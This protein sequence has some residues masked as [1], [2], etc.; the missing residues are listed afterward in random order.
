MNVEG[1][2][3]KV[4]GFDSWTGGIHHYQRLTAALRDHGFSLTLVHL[5]SWG[6]DPGRPK[7]ELIGDI[8]VRDV[9]YYDKPDLL[10]ILEQEAPAAVLFLSTDTFAHRAFN[11]YCRMKGIPTLNLYH[12]LVRVQA[13]DAG[14]PYRINILAH[15]RFVSARLLKALQLVWPAYGKALWRTSASLSAW[16]RFAKDI[17]MGGL[18]RFSLIS[19]ED[20]R[21]DRCGVYVAADIVHAVTKYGFRED[22][23]TAVGN[24]DLSRFG[25][26]EAA[27]GSHVASVSGERK[28]VMYVDTGLIYTG[29][30]FNSPAEFIGH[31]VDTSRALAQIG[32]SLVFKPHPDHLRTDVP[33]RLR[34][35]GIEV[36]DNKE[37]VRRLEGC[38]ASIVEP[39]TLAV[40]PALI[41][42]PL[43]LAQYGRLQEQRF[44]SVLE[45]Y[46]RAQKLTSLAE[47]G[48]VYA[49]SG[50]AIN[51]DAVKR[52]IAE[53][54]GPMPPEGMPAR[55]CELVESMLAA[56]RSQRS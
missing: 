42:M 35:A 31:M 48:S 43:W 49:R 30:V 12:G 8:P 21:T 19:A 16:R 51:G 40:I 37:F 54:A 17:L 23:V 28:A 14:S 3:T 44:G 11:R 55:V 2:L 33:Q 9:S 38:C 46:P 26:G 24:P 4:L 53:N 45:S 41:G 56:K 36:C 47:M 15:V 7:S 34:D 50:E 6:S 5:G 39:S 32:L 13:V 25:L 29:Y 22:Q 20:A 18:G 52:W 1:E 27:I 10:H